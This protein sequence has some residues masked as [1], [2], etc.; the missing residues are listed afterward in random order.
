[1]K[2]LISL[3]LAF[4]MIV[5][6]LPMNVMADTAANN[7]PEK[8]SDIS[9]DMRLND[10]YELDLSEYFA[11]GDGDELT[12]FVSEDGAA[13]KQLSIAQYRYYPAGSG[14]QKVYFKAADASKESEILTLTAS[15]KK[16][17]NEVTVAFSVT[18]GTDKFYTVEETGKTLF[19]E[20][21]TVPYF[22][23]SKYGLSQYYYNPQCY[24][25]HSDKDTEASNSQIPGTKETAND[26]VTLMH[27][28]I[29]ATEVLYLGYD[30]EDAG[31]GLSY[32]QGKLENAVSWTGG[33]G[34]SF[35]DFWDHGTN[36][37]YYV[38]WTYPVGAH[39]WG[40]TS[41]QIALYGGED[42]SIHLIKSK[43]ATGSDFTFFTADGQYKPESQVEEVK[44]AKGSKITLTA[45][46]TQPDWNHTY[47]TEFVG[48]AN[49]N[50]V[51]IRAD[52]VEDSLK[53]WSSEPFG[54]N[55]NLTTD[56]K[57]QIVIDS[58]ELEI[59][60]YYVAVYGVDTGSTEIGPA[61]VQLNVVCEHDWKEA[62]C[63]EPKT[64]TIC[65]STTGSSLGHRWMGATCQAPK[66][67]SGCGKTEGE[68][69]KDAHR[70]ENGKCTLC[71]SFEPGQEQYDSVPSLTG[72][73]SVSTL[74]VQ[75]D[76]FELDLSTVFANGVT[77][78]V[79]VDSQ[80]SVSTSKKFSY[81]GDT[82][83]THKLVFT[84]A[85]PVGESASYTVNMTVVD[86]D[87]VQTVN[88]A[89]KGGTIAWFA[90]TDENYNALPEG[91]TYVW[92]AEKSTF[93]VTQ[94][95]DINLNG[96]VM[97]FYNLVKDTPGAKLPLFTG[98]TI[99]NGA[100]TYWDSAVRDRQTITLVNGEGDGEVYLYETAAS[101]AN[102]VYTT[103]R[104]DLNRT[105]PATY[106][107]YKTSGHAVYTIA[108]EKGGVNGHTWITSDEVHI[109]L[110]DQTPADAQLVFLEKKAVTTLSGGAGSYSW[111]NKTIKYKIDQYPVLAEGQETTAVANVPAGSTYK[112]DL[113]ALFTDAD[114]TDSL[115]YRVKINGGNM[116]K[117]SGSTYSYTPST[118][119]TYTL[120]FYAYDGF[121]Y[122]EDCYTVTL[123]AVNLA[124]TFD[125]TVKNLP[126][127][128]E[129]YYNNGFNS[130][131]T[132]ILGDKL[133][134]EYVNG[135]YTVKVPENVGCIAIVM[136]GCRITAEVSASNNAITMQ[137]TTFKVYTKAGNLADGTVSVT[138]GGGH[139]AV[140]QNNIFWLVSGD[141]YLFEAV[142]SEEYAQ[143]WSRGGKS[144][145]VT[146][147]AEAV[148]IIPLEVNSPK[149]I[150]I[151]KGAEVSV[152]YQ[153]GYYRMYRVNPVLTKDNGDNTI[154]YTYACPES[155]VYARGYM[156]FATKGD[157]IDKAGYMNNVTN[158][159]ITWEGETRLNTHRGTNDPSLIHTDREDDSVMV[160]INAQNHLILNP[161]DTFRLR[162]F[163]IWEIIN[164]DTENVMIEP[165]FIYSNYD[166]NLV[167][168]VS[169]NEAL[170]AA[171][172]N[173]E[174]GTG[175]NNWMDMTVKGA[176]LTFMEVSYE[177]IHIVDGYAGG[178]WGG[179]EGQAGNFLYSACDPA[180]TALIVI[181]TDG[182]AATDVE[183]G[184]QCLSSF[185]GYNDYYTGE[186]LKKWDVEFD[187]LYFIGQKGEMTLSPSVKSGSIKSVAISSDKGESWT[188][189]EAVN[190]VYTAD[191]Y[192]GNNVI[193]VTKNDGTTAYQVVRG[194]AITYTTSIT[195]DRD[196]DGQISPGDT[197]KVKL[198]G[199]HNP[200]GKMSGIYNPGFSEGQRV[201][202]TFDGKQVRQSS[203][204]QYSFVTNAEIEVTVP[205][206]AKGTYSLTD[207]Y[208]HF[209][210]FG[211]MPGSHRDLTDDGRAVNT[212]AE[213]GK[214]TR[215]LLPDILIYEGESPDEPEEPVLQGDVN[216]DGKVSSLDLSKLRMYLATDSIEINEKNADMNEDGKISSLDLSKLRKVLAGN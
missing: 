167:S 44:V 122:S 168:L 74:A 207:G 114:E 71:G 121:V 54:G 140:G 79:S 77:Y 50:W 161:G 133:E 185:V 216:G 112:I 88:H 91:T 181:Q 153:W 33:V 70:Y 87:A 145:A 191:I 196:N 85:N 29:Y 174:C 183:F 5:G 14:E 105:K 9:I 78:K 45:V 99:C 189:L 151:D 197:V 23:L 149:T 194:D 113:S 187:T 124:E 108:G 67:C 198:H 101:S 46:Q 57:G 213:S 75:Y 84:A 52:E 129:F 16:P 144:Q 89:V 150:T 137:K 175:G 118:A 7:S 20:E 11:D 170:A 157:L 160:N 120:A 51:W 117:V 125:V 93:V 155:Q 192:S 43:S 92:N 135:L 31:T 68:A 147:E 62:A 82:A 2:K 38:D 193:R 202:Y 24:S 111:D 8:K 48:H 200:V 64:C 104:F 130:D 204:H 177:A 195:N 106:F 132:D 142:P 172:K 184:I 176:G 163:R 159:N 12:Y 206:D 182:K 215:S 97:V 56:E 83:G 55:T 212:T 41:D 42:V 154:T 205:E 102:N 152:F 49:K 47:D 156:Y 95:A 148:V 131:G 134:A 143:E 186:G 178:S 13:W 180:R 60:E 164:T 100:G 110:N 18:Q 126:E 1:M 66:T 96:K 36:L 81:S 90:F 21:L 86:K 171:G 19:A 109:A 98:S 32:K 211:D 27:V 201:A 39:K 4:V 10:W 65:G 76:L 26:I 128:A 35:M 6:I 34:S 169:A 72:A 199:L 40:S 58:T 30:E 127:G 80:E 208:I 166:E 15:V 115:N 107:E 116:K 119:G 28:F 59:G 3:L 25:T 173:Q 17:P 136:D 94:P 209:N 165:Q 53:N 146:T 203:Y 190:G 188:T 103:V 69:D 123:T 139:K 138:Y 63:T 210:I 37:N 22:D 61:I 73:A 214:H 141:G 158:T 179:A 162:A